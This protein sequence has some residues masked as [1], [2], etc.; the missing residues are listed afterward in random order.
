MSKSLPSQSQIE[1]IIILFEDG[2]LDDALDSA[3][4]LTKQFPNKLTVRN[5]IFEAGSSM[6]KYIER[7]FGS[8][9]EHGPHQSKW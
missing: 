5:S 9:T 6:R 1:S 8:I 7:K 3:Q 2:Q 4:N